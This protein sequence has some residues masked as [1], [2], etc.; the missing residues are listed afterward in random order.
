MFESP[1]PISFTK[2]FPQ[3]PHCRSG[4]WL[5]FWNFEALTWMESVKIQAIDWIQIRE[6]RLHFTR[7]QWISRDVNLLKGC[8][9]ANCWIIV[10]VSGNQ[11]FGFRTFLST[12][13]LLNVVVG[14]E[15]KQWSLPVVYEAAWC[16][17]SSDCE[18]SQTLAPF[19]GQGPTWNFT[20][21]FAFKW[22]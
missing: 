13:L 8:F 1:I 16:L 20:G 18:R 5:K 6:F 14:E 11:V 17:P 15:T 21:V 9:Q 3:T 2:L 12:Q 22:F 7:S 10:F 19:S 4:S